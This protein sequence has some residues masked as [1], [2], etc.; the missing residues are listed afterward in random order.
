[1]K[2]GLLFGTFNPVHNGHMAIANYF[3]EFTGLDRVWLVVSPQNPLKPASSL[4]ADYH[5]FRLVEIAIG[6]YRRLK[7]SR[8]EFNLPRPSYTVHTLAYLGEE[9]PGEEFVLIMG[10]DN[11]ETLHRW[12]NHEQIL[13]GYSIYVYPRLGHDG[14]QYKQHPRVQWTEAP[15]VQISASF[16]RNAIAAKKDV[17]FLLPESVWKYIEEMH[18][19]EKKGRE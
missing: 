5:R 8:I 16:I 14:G 4:L 17:R 9:H 2:T 10:A 15:I 7:A 6:D 1:M 18:F 19:Y 12:K 13:A 11:L 3:A